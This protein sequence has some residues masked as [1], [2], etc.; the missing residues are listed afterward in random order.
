M[1]G[2]A[3]GAS[4][5]AVGLS[6]ATRV[7]MHIGQLFPSRQAARNA[8]ETELA[9]A[10]RAIKNGKSAGMRQIHFS[11]LVSTMQHMCMLVG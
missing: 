3:S 2:S 1:E 4:A 6:L 8:A 9:A 11:C 5:A 7:K 10:G